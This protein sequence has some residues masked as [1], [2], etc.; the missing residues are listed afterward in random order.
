MAHKDGKGG[1]SMG[2]DHQG[3]RPAP[4]V[5]NKHVGVGPAPKPKPDVHVPVRPAPTPPKAPPPK[6]T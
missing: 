4:D 2:Q 1:H 6:K 3:V 5:S